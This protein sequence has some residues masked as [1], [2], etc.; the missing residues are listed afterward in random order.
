MKK[1]KLKLNDL[2]VISFLTVVDTKV[3]Q[4]VKGGSARCND[5]EASDGL[6]GAVMMCLSGDCDGT[7]RCLGTAQNC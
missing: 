2:R 1:G 6:S 5:P 3:S 7:N 4:T